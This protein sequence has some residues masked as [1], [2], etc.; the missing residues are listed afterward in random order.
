MIIAT[1]LPDPPELL[2]FEG[3]AKPDQN[4]RNL[5]VLVDDDI[6]KRGADFLLCFTERTRNS[7]KMPKNVRLAFKNVGLFNFERGEGRGW[8]D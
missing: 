8:Q 1:F 7:L 4:M 2:G 3:T 6:I 5:I